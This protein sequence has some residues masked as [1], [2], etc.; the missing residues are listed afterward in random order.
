[1]ETESAVTPLLY[2]VTQVMA[3]T[4]L[5]RSVI[6]EQMKSGELESVT[7]ERAD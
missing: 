7:A 4:G 6:Y 5:G 2:S 3:M 1:M